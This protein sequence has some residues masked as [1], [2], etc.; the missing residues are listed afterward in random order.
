MFV[1][2]GLTPKNIQ[3]IQ[4][5]ASP[6]MK[7]FKDKGRLSSLVQSIPLF[8]VLDDDLGLYGA[9]FVALRVSPPLC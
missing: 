4:G 9:W 3:F 7:A 8:A 5:D 1:T 2:G 6:F